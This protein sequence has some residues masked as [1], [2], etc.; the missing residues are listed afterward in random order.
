MF[1]KE[2]SESFGEEVT[3]W[4]NFTA[5]AIRCWLTL[6]ICQCSLERPL[7]RGIK[8]IGSWILNSNTLLQKFHH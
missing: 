2:I 8:E 4:R 5:P 3:V 1:S 6:N 7:F